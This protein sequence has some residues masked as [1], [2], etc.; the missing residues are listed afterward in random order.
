MGVCIGLKI[1]FRLFH[2]PQNHSVFPYEG[3]L[4]LIP[5]FNYLNTEEA[6]IELDAVF[7]A[8]NV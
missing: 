1:V 5:F 3:L 8:K 2:Q 7:Q 6:L 4:G